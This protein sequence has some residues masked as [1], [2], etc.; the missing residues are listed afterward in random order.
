VAGK[1]DVTVD[2]TDR[3]PEYPAEVVAQPE[4]R[5]HVVIEAH[6]HRRHRHLGRVDDGFILAL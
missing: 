2:V 1:F 5:E 4:L 6:L 3:L